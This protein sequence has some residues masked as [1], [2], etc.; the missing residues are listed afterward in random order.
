MQTFTCPEYEHES[1]Y[2]PWVESAHCPECGYE[3]T[4]G[5]RVAHRRRLRKKKV[6]YQPLLDELLA[7][8]NGSHTPALDFTLQTADLALAFFKDYQRMLGEEPDALAGYM[9]FKRDY[10]PKRSE[11]LMFVGA[12]L[13][14]KQ[15][16][17]A[18]AAR[19]LRALTIMA[20]SPTPGSG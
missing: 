14:L 12:Y 7:H 6:A 16:N 2:D 15:G 18:Q 11:I 3:P 1:T 17:R 20:S 5:R 19:H 8:W 9:E 13:L 4:Q 10:Q